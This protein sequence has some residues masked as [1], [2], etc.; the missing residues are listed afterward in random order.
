MMCM[1]CVFEPYCMSGSKVMPTP[2]SERAQTHGGRVQH[3]C[4]EARTQSVV[5][6][7]KY[8]CLP[9]AKRPHLQILE[10]G[11]REPELGPVE[12]WA[13]LWAPARTG[14]CPEER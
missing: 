9:R 2:A 12:T 13:A 1:P 11:M 6:G 7:F 5:V 4:Q 10:Y 8:P 14:S 3:A